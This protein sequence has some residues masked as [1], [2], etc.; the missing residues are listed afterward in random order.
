MKKRFISV[1]FI[2]TFVFGIVS[3]PSFAA[4][5]GGGSSSDYAVQFDDCSAYT[6]Y[7]SDDTSYTPFTYSCPAINEIYIMVVIDFNSTMKEN[8]FLDLIIDFSTTNYYD[9]IVIEYLELHEAGSSVIGGQESFDYGGIVS[10]QSVVFSDVLLSHDVTSA[11]VKFKISGLTTNACHFE[12]SDIQI[13]DSNDTLLGRISRIARNIWNSILDLPERFVYHLK[14]GLQ[15]LFVPS[16]D[17]IVDIKDKFT[18]LLDDRF[19]AVYDSAQIIDDFSNS[20]ISQSQSAMADGEGADGFVTFPAVT[21]NLAG[22]DFT[23]GGY[24]VDLV[25]NKFDGIVDMLKMITN[26][27]CTLFFV[28]MLKRKLEGVLS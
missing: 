9:N 7:S 10:G 28:N 23:F 26:I 11:F 1:L 13:E 18:Q 3:I 15:T 27:T 17:D 19:G 25:P 8:S 22:A 21:V 20:F 5:P 16:E 24:E 6:M 4:G 14:G 12:L 2:F